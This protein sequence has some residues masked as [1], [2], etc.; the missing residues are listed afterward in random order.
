[1]P[2]RPAGRRRRRARKLGRAAALGGV[3]LAIFWPKTWPKTWPTAWPSASAA[4]YAQSPGS[5]SDGADG[6]TGRA[7][8]APE[9]AQLEKAQLERTRSG[10]APERGFSEAVFVDLTVG[11]VP[12]ANDVPLM[13]GAGVR[14]RGVHELWARGGY[15]PVGDDIGYGFGCGGYRAA[16]R[17]HRRVRP[18]L[19]G[20]IAGLRATCSHDDTGRPECTKTPLF[21][22]AATAGVRIE[23]VPW[24]GLS[25]VLSL[26]VDSYPNPFGMLELGVSFALPQAQSASAGRAAPP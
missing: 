5:S 23:P 10:E 17:P 19:G 7:Q 8:D 6:Q 3:C 2:M 18:V 24:L 1:M 9:K 14:I 15:I 26:G 12:Y 11:F 13:L 20:L 21:I 16:L 25:A 22:F 4:P